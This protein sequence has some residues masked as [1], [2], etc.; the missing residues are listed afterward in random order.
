MKALMA[1][2]PRREDIGTVNRERDDGQLKD[3]KQC[4]PSLDSPHGRLRTGRDYL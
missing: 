4:S 1:C 2:G 3:Q